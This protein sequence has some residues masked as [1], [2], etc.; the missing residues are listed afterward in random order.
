MGGVTFRDESDNR[1][2]VGRRDGQVRHAA[3]KKS[4]EQ[5]LRQKSVLIVERAGERHFVK[6]EARNAR[7]VC[8]KYVTTYVINPTNL[9]PKRRVW[10]GSAVTFK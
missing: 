9:S 10:T 4:V 8:E 6:A 5:A 7:A 3:F 2:S 1:P